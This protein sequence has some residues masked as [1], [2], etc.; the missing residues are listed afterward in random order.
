MKS[1]EVL[2]QLMTE[3]LDDVQEVRI[4]KKKLEKKDFIRSKTGFVVVVV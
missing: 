4:G 3:G 2:S 1:G